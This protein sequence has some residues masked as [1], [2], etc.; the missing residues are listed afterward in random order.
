MLTQDTLARVEA[1]AIET[2]NVMVEQFGD[3]SELVLRIFRDAFTRKL[4]DFRRLSDMRAEFIE[5]CEGNS[6]PRARP[7][8]QLVVSNSAEVVE[9][10]FR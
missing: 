1:R 9:A 7:V 3:D 8:L 4:A 5:R 6:V 10:P 2:A